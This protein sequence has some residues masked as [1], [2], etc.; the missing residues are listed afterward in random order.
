MLSADPP[1]GLASFLTLASLL[2]SCSPCIQ[3]KHFEC[4][5]FS[6][7][8][9]PRACVGDMSPGD[10]DRLVPGWL[11]RDRR[12]LEGP[13]GSNTAV[14]MPGSR[15]CRRRCRSRGC[16]TGLYSIEGAFQIRSLGLEVPGAGGC[17]LAMGLCVVYRP[18]EES[19]LRRSFARVAPGGLRSWPGNC[20]RHARM[21]WS[22]GGSVCRS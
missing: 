17:H 22:P 4:P 7:W 19:R 9:S 15:L 11:R 2:A 13:R 20:C 12:L 3:G 21:G 14:T 16:R 8:A 6:K 1:H 5:W 10:S 18:G